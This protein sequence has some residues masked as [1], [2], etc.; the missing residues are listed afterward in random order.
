MVG[1]FF[2]SNDF[3]TITENF[4]TPFYG[5]FSPAFCIHLFSIFVY[6]SRGFWAD[7]EILVDTP[8]RNYTRKMHFQDSLKFSTKSTFYFPGIH[9]PIAI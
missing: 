9:V 4:A 5:V 1:G 2:K 8:E 6:I 3:V 7:D